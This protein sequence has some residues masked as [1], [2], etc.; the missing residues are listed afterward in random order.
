MRNINF[1]DTPKHDVTCRALTT[2]EKV[3]LKQDDYGIKKYNKSLHHRMPYGWLEMFLEEM[4]DG[5][6][7]IQ[8]EIDRKE[9][10]IE[11][12]KAAVESDNPKPLVGAVIKILE[13]SGTG[14]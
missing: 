2:L 11:M 8:N 7:Y 13:M 4:A 9:E 3:M 1:E 14:K 5:L 12:L 10:I 6:K